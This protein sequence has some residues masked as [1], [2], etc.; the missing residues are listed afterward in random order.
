MKSEEKPFGDDWL[1]YRKI[2]KEQARKEKDL[3]SSRQEEAKQK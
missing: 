1:K 2:V 3:I